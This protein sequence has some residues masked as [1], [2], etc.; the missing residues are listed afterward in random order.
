MAFD[1]GQLVQSLRGGLNTA[2]TFL[3]GSGQLINNLAGLLRG[4][5]GTSGGVQIQTSS[6]PSWLQ[7]LL[8]AGLTVGGALA[9]KEPGEVTEA[10]QFLRNQFTSPGAT[11][12][13]M[14]N[15]V[16]GAQTALAPLLG[17]VGPTGPGQNYL[18]SLF[19]DPQGMAQQFSQNVGAV[20]EQF[21]PLLTQQRQRGIDD[22]SQRFAAAF[23]SSVGAQGPEFGTLSRYITDEALP[24]EQA[25]LGQLG[26]DLQNRQQN[27]AGS[28]F[29]DEANR[30]SQVQNLAGQGLNIPINAAG[31]I[32]E[33]SKPDPLAQLA[34]LIGS[35]MLFNGGAGGTVGGL[36][37]L[38]GGGTGQAGQGGSLLDQIGQ[39]VN[40][41]A[42]QSIGQLNP[43]E[44]ASQLVGSGD[45]TNLAA[46]L[47]S[48]ALAGTPFPVGVQASS[49]AGQLIQQAIN[50]GLVE[51]P[52]ATA[53]GGGGAAAAGFDAGL[54][55][56]GLLG[57]A[58][59]S[60]GAGALSA[61]GSAVGGGAVG[62]TVGNAIASWYE[63]NNAGETSN[64]QTGLIGAG[65]GAASGALA[66][67]AVG[68]PMGA[69][70]GAIVGG[71]GGGIFGAGAEKRRE[72]ALDAQQIAET[73][74][75][76]PEVFATVDAF[77]G[78]LNAVVPRLSAA[79]DAGAEAII[80]QKLAAGDPNVSTL[81]NQ[82]RQ[83]GFTRPGF[84][85]RDIKQELAGYAT[86]LTTDSGPDSLYGQ[87]RSWE[88]GKFFP[89]AEKVNEW[90]ARAAES[91]NLAL[92]LLAAIGG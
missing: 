26:L 44:L 75:A 76:R 19:Q 35:N 2:N 23:P 74:A 4:G 81:V 68:G 33:T 31:T 77:V 57:P 42:Y 18:T 62:T 92:Q 90:Q 51:S 60:S 47:S 25:F 58:G 16:S 10:R 32:L 70:I 88:T 36:G 66:G 86:K 56:P 87:L 30:R 82:A 89:G 20:S 38:S 64:L 3:G 85:I 9:D 52:A 41:S 1:W 71:I 59:F 17:Q 83:M 46:L 53:V 72:D 12:Q 11:G 39:L 54:A 73:T 7:P 67:F 91:I 43:A 84:E 34:S 80:R 48:G 22:I 27:A 65:G 6:L 13:L 5:G 24:R 8:G 79:D 21:Q 78:G 55:G 69:L 61:L 50:A 63:G 14:G 28:V 37:G 45:L 29:Q 40:P 49:A 15:S